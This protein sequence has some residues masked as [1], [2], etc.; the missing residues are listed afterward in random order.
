V[1]SGFTEGDFDG[2][3]L[4][5]LL[6]FLL[7][8]MLGEV[9]GERLGAALGAGLDPTG[10]PVSAILRFASLLSKELNVIVSVS[11]ELPLKLMMV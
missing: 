8:I 6:G 4:G 10:K 11:P 5:T 7:G 1:G 2:S 9:L 3:T